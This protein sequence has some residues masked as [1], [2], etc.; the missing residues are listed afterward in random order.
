[1][2]YTRFIESMMN[3]I[4]ETVPSYAES[5]MT[6]LKAANYFQFAAGGALFG[7]GLFAGGCGAAMCKRGL[8]QDP[9][10]GLSI[11]GA[12]SGL[13]LKLALSN[14]IWGTFFLTGVVTGY[15]I[16]KNVVNTLKP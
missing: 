14:P 1:M 12:A 3:G 16:E 7:F 5:A 11:I 9:G 6:E 8:H 2:A 10:L 15:Q 4:V 13:V